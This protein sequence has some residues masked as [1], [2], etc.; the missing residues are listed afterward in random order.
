M[1][2]ARLEVTEAALCLWRKA[3]TG[4]LWTRRG[5]F[6]YYQEDHFQEYMA[7]LGPI[8]TGMT[9]PEKHRFFSGA[10][11]SEVVHETPKEAPTLADL[12]R[13]VA[14]IEATLALNGA[15]NG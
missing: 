3:G 2:A 1:V 12:E 4:P 6:V 10:K 5:H 8:P 11:L 7:A 9:R 15:T 14:V 13:R